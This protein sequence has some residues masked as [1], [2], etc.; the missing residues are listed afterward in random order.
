MRQL[1]SKLRTLVQT[2]T[3]FKFSDEFKKFIK[4]KFGKGLVFLL[5]I[6]SK[7][8]E[9]GI[10]QVLFLHKTFVRTTNNLP[11]SARFLPLLN[12]P[13]RTPQIEKTKSQTI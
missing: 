7:D 6:R 12:T 11:Q 13:K 9:S 10:F 5:N 8:E 3:F 1:S 2:K 4:T